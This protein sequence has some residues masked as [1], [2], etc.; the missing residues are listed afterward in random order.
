MGMCMCTQVWWMTCDV[1]S[2]EKGVQRHLRKGK[3]K[4]TQGN[5]FGSKSTFSVA[6]KVLYRHP[7]PIRSWGSSSYLSTHLSV[8]GVLAP[9][10]TAF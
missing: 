10:G 1:E 3:V 4:Q 6:T 2:Q 5:A 7:G 8:R 9:W